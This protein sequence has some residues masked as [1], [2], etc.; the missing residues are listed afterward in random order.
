MGLGVYIGI[1]AQGN[2]RFAT[3]SRRDLLQQTQ[4]CFGFDI[5]T[6]NSHR[7]RPFQLITTLAD[8]GKYDLASIATRRQHA[9]QFAA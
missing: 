4:L 1:D 5:E 3:L 7:Q 9:L 6:A 8:P 2:R